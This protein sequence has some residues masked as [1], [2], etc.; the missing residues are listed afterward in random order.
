MTLIS[1]LEQAEAGSRELSCTL[2]KEIGWKTQAGELGADTSS[3]WAWWPNF[4]ESI[5]AAMSLK[6]DGHAAAVGTMFGNC[7]RK[8]WACIW[9]PE[10]EPKFHA[11]AA[12]PALALCVASLKAAGYE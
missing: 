2:A 12:T 8:P 9:T 7:S 1:R 10:G 6:P 5:D 4:T 11:E 3:P